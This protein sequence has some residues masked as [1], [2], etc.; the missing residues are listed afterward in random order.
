MVAFF[1]VH[2]FSLSP[3]RLRM[4]TI[5]KTNAISDTSV[6]VNRSSEDIDSL[7]NSRFWFME[8][9]ETN[10]KDLLVVGWC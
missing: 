6:E 4:K 2:V 5:L 9:F 1:A 8:E 10:G 3:V 7:R